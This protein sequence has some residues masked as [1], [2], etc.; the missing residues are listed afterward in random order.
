MPRKFDQVYSSVLEKD[1]HKTSKGVQ[2]T[3]SEDEE[4]PLTIFSKNGC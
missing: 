3:F 2:K 1:E 4:E